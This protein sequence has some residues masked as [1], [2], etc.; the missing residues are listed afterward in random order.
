MA[1]KP[2]HSKPQF[3]LSKEERINK[4]IAI[5]ELFEKGSSFRLYPLVVKFLPITKDD[6][7]DHS[8]NQ[9][10]FSV[11][12]RNFKSAVKRNRI[13]RQ[14]REAYRLYKQLF[15]QNAEP[16]QRYFVAYIYTAREFSPFMQIQK[17]MKESLNRLS[18]N[19]L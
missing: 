19:K 13:K 11:S 1:E 6:Q 4:D 5:K 3:T 12:K 18:K 16:D 17:Q 2:T 10:L 14:L 7:S 9:V 15:Y 8:L